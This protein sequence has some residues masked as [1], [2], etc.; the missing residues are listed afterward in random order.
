[1]S[2]MNEKTEAV[3]VPR[4]LIDCDGVLS[5]FRQQLF[6]ATG[7]EPFEIEEWDFIGKDPRMSWDAANKSASSRYF[8]LFMEPFQGARAFVKTFDDAY[9]VTSPWYSSQY[10]VYE[11][12]KWIQKNIG[13]PNKRVVVTSAK[14]LCKG[15]FFIDDKLQNVVNWCEEWPDGFGVVFSDLDMDKPL[16]N[17]AVRLTTYREVVEFVDKNKR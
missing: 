7:V 14:H 1:M 17:N 13:L 3:S 10:W 5:N 11:R 12:Y 4:V 15:D 2:L 8:C 6:E 16:P 9:I